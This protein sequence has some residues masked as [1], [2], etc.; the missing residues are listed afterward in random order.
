MTQLSSGMSVAFE[1]RAE[2]AVAVFRDTAGGY[3]HREKG[4][5]VGEGGKGKRGED[6]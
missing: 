1:V 3:V 2:D 6:G 5:E 4:N